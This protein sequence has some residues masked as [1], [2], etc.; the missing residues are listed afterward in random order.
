M[1]LY[2][3]ISQAV[4][5]EFPLENV[6]SPKVAPQLLEKK[7]EKKTTDNKSLNIFI[8]SPSV[9]IAFQEFA[10]DDR[11]TLINLLT[12]ANGFC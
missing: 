10:S 6:A 8:T 4:A 11:F 3:D 1:L 7:I 12:P 5:R 9:A 2:P